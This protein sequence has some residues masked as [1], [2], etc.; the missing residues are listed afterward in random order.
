MLTASRLVDGRAVWW[1]AGEW[2]EGFKNAEL[3]ASE[4][5]A[6]AALAQAEGFVARNVVVNPY[7]FDVRVTNG[8]ARPVREKEIIR[9]EGPSLDAWASEL[10]QESHDV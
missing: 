9:S 7:L 1:C 4:T 3:L 5:E 10:R 2:A 6:Q 8:V